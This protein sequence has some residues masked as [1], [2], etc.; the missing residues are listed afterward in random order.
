[1]H[2]ADIFFIR[3]IRPRIPI[4]H[5]DTFQEALTVIMN[6][7]GTV[8]IQRMAELTGKNEEEVT[9]GLRGQIFINP[10][11]E[12]WETS[13]EYLSGNVRT[14]LT[15]AI[16]F[17][18]KQDFKDKYLMNIEALKAVQPKDLEAHEIDV[19]LGA[20]WVTEGDICT[21]VGHI[22][23]LN[24]RE[25]ES[26]VHVRYASAIA[27]WKVNLTSG[28]YNILAT[29]TW[30]TS[31][32]N[33]IDIIE[34]SLNLRQITVYDYDEEGNRHLNREETI[35]ARLKQDAVKEEFKKWIFDDSERR[36][37]LVKI[38][39]EK[40]NCIK[41]R[42]FNGNFLTL[43]GMTNSIILDNHQKDAIARILFSGNSVLLDHVVGAGKT[44]TMI[45]S[46]MELKR[47]GIAKKPIFVVPNHL[48][49]QWGS[50][51][52]KLYPNAK[53]LMAVKED[54]EKQNR[55]RL[56]SRIATGDWDAV[57]IA[58]SSFGKM[59]ISNEW[60]A[61]FIQMQ[62]DML[63]AAIKEVSAGK[64]SASTRMVKQ[65]EKSRKKLEEKMQRLLDGE[66]KDNTVT[67]EELGVDYINV[68]EA[69]LFKNLFI[70]TKMGNVAGISTSQSKRAF[71]MFIKTQYIYRMNNRR[72]IVF[73][74]G[75]PISNSMAEMYTM[76][77]YLAIDRLEELGL[78]SFDSWAS[79]FGEIVSSLELSPDG[80]GYRIKQRFC[81]FY[82]LPEL[83]TLYRE[84]ADVK[85]DED[86]NL[87]KPKLMG[88]K[89]QIIAVEATEDLKRK[90]D[91]LVARSEA[92]HNGSV[93]PWED[94]MLA[95]TSEGRK[96]ALDMRILDPSIDDNPDFKVNA[97]VAN[98]FRTWE[99]T[100]ENRLTQI[101]FCDLSVP[102]KGFN[103]YDDIRNKLLKL[104]MPLEEIQ[105]MHDANTDIKKA[106]LFAKVRSGAVA[107][108]MGSTE[109]MGAGTN[110][111]DRL[112][113]LHHICCPWRPR[114]IQQREG[115]ILRRGNMNP[116]VEIC[117]Y[118]TKGSFDAYSWQTVE[119][120][121]KFISQIK[122]GNLA[123][124]TM[125][126]IDSATL[127]YAEVKAIASGNPKIMEKMQVDNEIQRLHVV[128]SS[129]IATKY[130]MQDKLA[131]MP[132]DIMDLEKRISMLN[133]D[134]ITRDNN[135]Q[136]EFNITVNDKNYVD[137]KEAGQAVLSIA[138]T[139]IDEAKAMDLRHGES[140]YCEIG[141]YRGFKLKV[142]YVRDVFSMLN[143]V[144]IVAMGR[145]VYDI[146]LSDSALG[147]IA[148]IENEIKGFNE[149]A[150]LRQKIY[151]SSTLKRRKI[152]Y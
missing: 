66:S 33:A 130:R 89:S 92:I 20:T 10:E 28:K 50:E 147:M 6:E 106:Q 35:A 84:F 31:R 128:K 1:M 12:R 18:Y 146:E 108:L 98:V 127:S 141:L 26:F 107:V 129:Y 59:P 81:K 69:D 132:K 114:D 25:I 142:K 117:R 149:V 151:L 101:V 38:Y 62:F 94:N 83:L 43:P 73:A 13:D 42:E 76:Q 90:T 82:N 7:I 115:R 121:A 32:A 75:T 3:T 27:T 61:Q 111:Q 104:G 136:D 17:N 79:T 70:Y 126:D 67:F 23:Q 150:W 138:G 100:R 133:E 96:A 44:Y 93:K 60:T 72:G 29:A 113:K 120:K 5:V 9:E 78:D 148:R 125:E 152:S 119:T 14:K 4:T 80:S 122:K 19:R 34:D 2:K 24:Q 77:R 112:Y 37:R 137:R 48:I 124:R 88:G 145:Y 16:E 21:F 54:F 103:V 87:P 86:L 58:H 8:D 56:F 39:N 71:D 97:V 85:T 36:G 131:S 143:K 15:A 134:L 140:A 95:I 57:I 55:K 135:T 144:Y 68:D 47:L 53:V 64:D 45:A 116:E 22:M 49:E 41:L 63:D 102:R 123:V 11:T 139:L 65:L 52:V 74:T 109:L 118:V 105:F 51:F 46:A 40:F 110:V 91:E 30:G 99:E